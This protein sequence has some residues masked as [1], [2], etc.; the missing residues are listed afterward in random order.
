[1][2]AGSDQ[3]DEKQPTARIRARAPFLFHRPFLRYSYPGEHFRR[4][5]I[6]PSGR[7]TKSDAL[8]KSLPIGLRLRTPGCVRC[9][10]G[11]GC[12]ALPVVSLVFAAKGAQERLV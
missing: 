2:L 11:C 9:M 1:M 7:S 4:R 3:P 8:G 6:R 5:S 10:G 12:T